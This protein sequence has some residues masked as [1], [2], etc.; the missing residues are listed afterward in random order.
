MS[1]D[2]SANRLTTTR[3]VPDNSG[4]TVNG[5]NLIQEPKGTTFNENWRWISG[6]RDIYLFENPL[7]ETK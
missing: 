5:L 6:T 4:V 1:E 7:F 3:F 2:N